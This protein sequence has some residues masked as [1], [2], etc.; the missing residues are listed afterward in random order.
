MKKDKN[1]EKYESP[2]TKKT[3]V[4]LESGFMN[5]SVFDPQNG[6][7]DGVSIEGHEVGNT[8][9]YTDIGWDNDGGT[10]RTWGN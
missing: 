6:Q 1:K 5:A 3:Q 9:D 10:G 4:N 7:D 8:G 2:F